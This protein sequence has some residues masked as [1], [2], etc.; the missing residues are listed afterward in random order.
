LHDCQP[1]KRLVLVRAEIDKVFLISDPH[2]L[3]NIAKDVMWSPEA[4]L[5]AKS[6][7][8]AIW[9]SKTDNREPRPRGITLEQFRAHTAG[10]NS[11]TWRDPVFFGSMLDYPK[12]GTPGA[13]KPPRRER[14]L[15]PREG[16]R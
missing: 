3:F 9:D 15:P 2:E 11:I 8:E 16:A 14:P 1:E 4:R 7:I 5:F 12:H 10:L 6:K 13:R